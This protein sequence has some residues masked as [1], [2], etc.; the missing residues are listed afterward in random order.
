[1]YKIL[2]SLPC[3]SRLKQALP[4]SNCSSPLCYL[5][6]TWSSKSQLNL[7][8]LCAHLDCSLEA[9]VLHWL[10]LLDLRGTERPAKIRTRFSTPL[11]LLAHVRELIIKLQS[12]P[13]EPPWNKWIYPTISRT[14]R[15]RV[16]EVGVRC[17]W[18]R[19]SVFCIFHCTSRSCFSAERWTVWGMQCKHVQVTLK[20]MLT[21]S[22]SHWIPSTNM[23]MFNALSIMNTNTLPWLQELHFDSQ[24]HDSEQLGTWLDHL[25]KT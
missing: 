4:R 15:F 14:C 22:A 24:G 7:L 25:I 23:S 12:R 9:C 5:G 2:L 20:K 18:A 1:M 8:S 13:F 21:A 19:T 6:A 16:I 3:N 11:W 10:L 17:F